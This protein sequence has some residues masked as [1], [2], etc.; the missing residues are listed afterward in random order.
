MKVFSFCI[1]GDKKKYC[2]G[3]VENIK[4]I[5]K[6]FPDYEI[7][8]YTG[9]NVPQNYLDE[10][11]N[12]PNT[13]LIYTNETGASLMCYRFFPIDD[14]LVTLQFTRDAD[15][16]IGER[17][18]WAI[19]EFIKSD[20]TFHII[21]DH[22]WHKRRITSGLMG[23]KR[24]AFPI[25]KNIKI[26]EL[27]NNWS[28][29]ISINK[30]K[31]DYD[32]DQLF[33]ETIVY[34]L[35][36]DNALIHSNIIGFKGENVTSI[37]HPLTDETLFMGN[38]VD[39]ENDNQVY[40]F[41]Y[42]DYPIIKHLHWVYN[43]QQNI[44]INKIAEYY[45]NY[46]KKLLQ[47]SAADRFIILN[48]A[49]HANIVL[50]N[51]TRS[52]QYFQ[53]FKY[54]HVIENIIVKSS[55]ILKQLQNLG[56]KVVGTTLSPKEYT[57]KNEKEFTIYYGNYYHGWYNLPTSAM[58]PIFVHGI[59]YNLFNHDEFVSASCWNSI[60]K[61]YIL[62][63]EERKDRFIEIMSELCKMGAP[64]N[65]IYHYKALKEKVTGIKDLDAY[66]GATKNHLDVVKHFINEKYKYCLIIEDDITFSSNIE[67]HQLD[68][69]TFF[70]RNYDFDVCLISTS[71]YFHIEEYDD[72]LNLSYQNCT[73]SSGYILSA[74]TAYKV[75]DCFETGYTEMIKTH[76]HE[77]Y[78]CDRYWAKLQKDNKFF[79]FKEKFA[80]QRPNFS[81]TTNT[82]CC[83]FD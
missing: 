17:D 16:R 70:K 32:T 83:Y 45:I 80:Y 73:T 75:L 44:I 23:I 42:Y 5:N 69:E 74:K 52:L 60:D 46:P 77:R 65:K 25:E 11:K 34:P 67:K 36:K 76:D 20:K 4:I 1:Y 53:L 82:S 62:N 66:I 79:V 61:I 28:N 37:D 50:N 51:P 40:S 2:Q 30:I 29:D 6:D 48:Y 22:Y 59:Y 41:K 55:Q 8:I 49:L 68:L 56:Y 18:K 15:S 57:L 43:E 54:T 19:N 33:N 26:E 9:T 14:Q 24:D 21:R 38:V 13:R 71:K 63:L 58:K 78:V 12:L 64:L 35:V 47:F 10:Y 7:W 3:L 81:N 39:Y 31:N 27:Y 72:L